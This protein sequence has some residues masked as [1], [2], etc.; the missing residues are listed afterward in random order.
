MN[1][2]RTS[3]IK[4]SF[5]FGDLNW[6]K[7]IDWP[8]PITYQA[9]DLVPRDESVIQFDLIHE[10]P[11]KADLIICA[12]LLNHLPHHH[13]R[14]ALDNLMASDAKYLIYTWWPA[15]ADFLDIGSDDSTVLRTNW[16]DSGKVSYEMRLVKIWRG[17]L[18]C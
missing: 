16:G 13:A 14:A 10:V 1:V 11:P 8:H 15:M 7:L 4:E 3:I 6:I 12:W 9:Y 5:Q 2:D 18:M 17:G